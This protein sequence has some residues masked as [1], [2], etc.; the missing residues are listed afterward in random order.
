ML[1]DSD[2]DGVID[3]ILHEGLF[4][5]LADAIEALPDSVFKKNPKKIK[6]LMKQEAKISIPL[7]KGKVS[8]AFKKLSQLEKTVNKHLANSIEVQ[9][10]E[11]TKEVILTL[12]YSFQ[13]ALKGSVQ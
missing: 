12:I 5:T 9:E 11:A 1:I 13:Q 4:R 3:G 2:G 8:K 10:G 7:S 6:K